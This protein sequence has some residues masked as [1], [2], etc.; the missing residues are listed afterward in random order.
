MELSIKKKVIF[1]LVTAIIFFVVLELLLRIFFSNTLLQL[2]FCRDKK[3]IA[4]SEYEYRP[5]YL[6]DK[7]LLW[8]HKPSIIA[9]NGIKVNSDG[10]RGDDIIKPKPNNVFRIVCLGDSCT[11]GLMI[12]DDR[13][14]YPKILE[15][16][17]NDEN[18]TNKRVEV[19]NGGVSGYS[20]YQG[21]QLL[22]NQVI[23]LQSNV[24]AI[25]YGLN[26]CIWANKFSD[27][28]MKIAP[29][30]IGKFDDF[31]GKFAVP[32]TIK[33]ILYYL[34]DNS[35]YVDSDSMNDL[36]RRVD[37]EDYEKNLKEIIRISREN[38]VKVILL[39]IAVRSKMPLIL[40]PIPKFSKVN[41]K[42]KVT[43]LFGHMIGEVSYWF[44]TKYEGSIESLEKEV[45]KNPESPLPHY[46]LA[47]YYKENSH[48]EL[49]KEEFKKANEL[50]I[51]R[52]IVMQY[53]EIIKKVAQENG[54]PL[55]DIYSVFNKDEMM[56]YFIDER[57]MDAEG[58]RIVANEILKTLIDMK[59][60]GEID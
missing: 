26:D 20:S 50:D 42:Y 18:V 19:I 58:N 23:G 35:Y 1:S 55:V 32:K 40:N 30:W 34:R 56:K 53:N 16:I 33:L 27:K 11:Y 60:H 43:F 14:V 21:L 12:K 24:I 37:L 9:N 13:E 49:A 4:N 47:E 36:E 15:K 29:V 38:Q 28:E 54:V 5:D 46:F 22:K 57:H 59:L 44:K 3:F 45:E 7:I 17:I 6:Q 31:F 2:D 39:N 51:T 25:Y 41:G 52:K 48:L 10:F 8:K